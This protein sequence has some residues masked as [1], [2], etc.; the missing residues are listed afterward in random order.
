[1]WTGSAFIE[2][3]ELAKAFGEQRPDEWAEQQL[4][5]FLKPRLGRSFSRFVPC[6]EEDDDSASPRAMRKLQPEECPVAWNVTVWVAYV[7]TGDVFVEPRGTTPFVSDRWNGFWEPREWRAPAWM[8]PHNPILLNGT[9]EEQS[10][11]MMSRLDASTSLE[12]FVQVHLCLW[13][14]IESALTEARHRALI[15]LL[16]TRYVP[17]KPHTPE[18]SWIEVPAVESK[19]A[20]VNAEYEQLYRV[21]EHVGALKSKCKPRLDSG[22]LETLCNELDRRRIPLPRKTRVWCEQEWEGKPTWTSALRYAETNLKSFLANVPKR[23]CQ[24]QRSA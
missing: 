23:Y 10:A 12:Q 3:F 6:C 15:D 2:Y 7:T 8:G 17:K 21:M 9:P 13:K 16:K 4:R 1:M 14:A 5:R 20:R 18:E 24:S 22:T 19:P 11:F